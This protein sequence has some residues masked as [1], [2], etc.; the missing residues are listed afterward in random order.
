MTMLLNPFARIGQL[1]AALRETQQIADRAARSYQAKLELLENRTT[2]IEARYRNDGFEVLGKRADTEDIV[3]ARRGYAGTYADLAGIRRRFGISKRLVNMHAEYCFGGGV[4]APTVRDEKVS[5]MLADWW[6]EPTNQRAMFNCE[7]QHMRSANLL[8]DG[9][10]FVA[11]IRGDRVNPM[12]VRRMDPLQFFDVITH[13]DDESAVLYYQRRYTPKLWDP[14]QDRWRDGG[15]EAVLYYPDIDNDG[16]GELDDPYAG[17]L[18]IARDGAGNPIHVLRYRMNALSP[19]DMG[20]GIMLELMEYE[21]PML[22]LVEDQLTVSAST[23][24]YMNTAVAKG[25]SKQ[26]SAAAAYLGQSGDNPTNAQPNAGDWT[27]TNEGLALSINR[28]GTQAGDNRQNVRMVQIPMAAISGTALHYMGD[29]E[30]A[31]LATAQAME[32]PVQKHFEAYQSFWTYIYARLATKAMADAG[33]DLRAGGHN[34]NVPMPELVVEDLLER[35]EA[36]GYMA[37]RDW[38]SRKQA[39]RLSWV[40]MGAADP[41]AETE[42]ALDAVENDEDDK[43]GPLTTEMTPP[44]KQVGEVLP[45]E[46][47]PPVPTA[48]PA[49]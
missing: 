39:T 31:N 33:T 38:A 29:P 30:N 40:A 8:V 3:K 36:I 16:T 27:I 6:F 18:N 32:G 5:Q 19:T 34:L 48:G 20:Q 13:P 22:G 1:E 24:A 21:L 4:E 23:A 37:D 9:S 35:M 14:A 25:G 7:A 15:T 44:A 12:L 41:T 49:E 10:L 47:A 43:Q 2:D 42:E 11:C 46:Q 26:V 45:D 28:A 17:E